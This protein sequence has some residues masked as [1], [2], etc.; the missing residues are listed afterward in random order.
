MCYTINA[1]AVL[2]NYFA[3]TKKTEVSF[4]ELRQLRETLESKMGK[5][6]YL[7]IRSDSLMRTVSSYRDFF[8]FKETKI[9][10]TSEAQ[11]LINRE[12]FFRAIQMNYNWRFPKD[13]MDGYIGL[14]SNNSVK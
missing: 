10:I 3:K 5:G 1:E 13:I 4:I 9:E 12:G 6:I 14:I 7:D 8:V 2:F 11:T